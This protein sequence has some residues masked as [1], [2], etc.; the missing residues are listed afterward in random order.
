MSGLWSLL[1]A[2]RTWLGHGGNDAFAPLQT[3][4]GCRRRTPAYAIPLP[5]PQVSSTQPQRCGPISAVEDDFAGQ[6]VESFV[7]VRVRVR[8]HTGARHEPGSGPF[9]HALVMAGGAR[10]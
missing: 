2:K 10:P 8:W 4:L 6:H 7:L 9:A 3:S 5:R 1:R